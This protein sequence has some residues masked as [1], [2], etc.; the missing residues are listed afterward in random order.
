MNESLKPF[1]NAGRECKFFR[2]RFLSSNSWFEPE[3]FLKGLMIFH[4]ELFFSPTM[5]PHIEF[6]WAFIFSPY[7]FKWSLIVVEMT[8]FQSQGLY[9]LVKLKKE[10]NVDLLLIEAAA[11]EP[12]QRTMGGCLNTIIIFELV[13]HSMVPHW[14]RAG[15]SLERNPSTPIY[16]WWWEKYLMPEAEIIILKWRASKNSYTVQNH[17]TLGQKGP[18]WS[19]CCWLCSSVGLF[20]SVVFL[21]LQLSTWCASCW[22]LKN[23][24]NAFLFPELW[25]KG[26]LMQ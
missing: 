10:F 8:F 20:R 19:P 12:S 26:F 2:Q 25:L 11:V 15:I 17:W 16:N 4:S 7:H 5:P 24:R 18:N 22:I 13:L 3:D 1:F 14:Y 9:C 21:Q 6:K 23:W